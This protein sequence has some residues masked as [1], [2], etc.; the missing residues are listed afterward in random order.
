MRAWR[1]HKNA[2]LDHSSYLLPPV[3]SSIKHP[4]E[5]PIRASIIESCNN[6]SVVPVFG[7]A[8]AKIPGNMALRCVK[9]PTFRSL[10]P[11]TIIQDRSN[12]ARSISGTAAVYPV[13]PTVE[14]H[15]ESEIPSAD[16]MRRLNI[17]SSW[18]EEPRISETDYRPSRDQWRD[19]PEIW[20]QQALGESPKKNKGGPVTQ[21][22]VREGG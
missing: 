1:V 3:P 17:F 16:V 9:T 8:V 20:T 22:L 11:I 14:L 15:H 4:S 10:C 18:C 5:A 21:F 13:I 2:G 19:T 7:R 6:M 12:M